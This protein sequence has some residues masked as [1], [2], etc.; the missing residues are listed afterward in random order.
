[1]DLAPHPSILA[2]LDALE[3]ANHRY[4]LAA[5]ALAVTCFAWVACGTGAQARTTLAAERIVL[6]DADGTE[7]ATL[8]SDSRGNPMLTLRNGKAFA[9]ITT[10]G[11]SL[12]LR[13][14]DGKTGA[15]LGIDS[16]RTSRLELCSHRLL[17]G[18]RLSSHEDG[19]SGVYVLDVD[20]RQ[21]GGLEAFGEG[22]AGLNFRDGLGRVRGSLG[23]DPK[24]QPNLL[25]LDEDGGRRLGMVLQPDGNPMLELADGRGRPR[26]QLSTLF[27]GSPILELKRDDGTVTYQAP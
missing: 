18:V 25:L 24:E 3:R 23:L 14:T 21:R 22:G 20:G 5:A 10:D 11:P 12:L 15:F 19:S 2:R 17:D 26:A 13:G 9:V 4:R 16:K 27:D 8:E 1:M 6:L 7:K